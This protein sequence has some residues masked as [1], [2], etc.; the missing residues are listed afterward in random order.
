MAIE[1]RREA[2]S[3][4]ERTR[5]IDFVTPS[6]GASAAV[7]RALKACD[8]AVY[9]D[10][11]SSRLKSLL[12]AAVGCPDAALTVISGTTELMHMAARLVGAGTLAFIAG[13]ADPEV[14][15]ACRAAGLI[16]AAPPLDSALG[17]DIA[18]ACSRIE[19]L[20]PGLVWLSTPNRVSGQALDKQSLE[21]IVAAPNVGVV[22]VDDSLGCFADD[23]HDSAALARRGNV[24][25]VRSLAPTHG[26]GGLRIGYAISVPQLAAEMEAHQPRRSVN[27]AAQQAA[28]VALVDAGSS[29]AAWERVRKRRAEMVRS[30]EAS[31]IRAL[32]SQAD[33]IW[34]EV[35][36]AAL[37]TQRI[38]ALGMHVVDGT[39]R[40]LPRHVRI[41]VR[42]RADVVALTDAMRRL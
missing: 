9:P 12:A 1:P 5:Q 32:P 31:G 20:R 40:G 13:P 27:I 14:E 16:T 8:P 38:A 18:T 25:V 37:F 21:A 15:R 2:R 3:R 29:S 17:W 41:A 42:A 7:R 4:P 6:I 33:F 10:E 24:V 28:L 22:V 30:L 34:I 23:P 35:G 39:L 11:G 26:I 19:Q 36:D